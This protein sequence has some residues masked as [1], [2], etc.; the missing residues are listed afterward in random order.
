MRRQ[1]LDAQAIV[2]VR[3]FQDPRQVHA[4]AIR[5]NIFQCFPVL[6]ILRDAVALG[7]EP[8]GIGEAPSRTS[9]D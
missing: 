2:F 1:H 5:Q 8:N 3:L 4:A 9:D 7:Q 6:F